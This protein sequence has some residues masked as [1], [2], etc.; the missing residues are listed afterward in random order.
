MALGLALGA[1]CARIVP[2][3]SSAKS[4]DSGRKDQTDE[5]AD[6]EAFPFPLE[7]PRQR[8]RMSE[9][10]VLLELFTGAQCPPCVAADIACDAVLRTYKPDEVVLLQYHLHIPR[11]D[12]LT[13]ADSEARAEYYGEAIEGTPTVFLDGKALSDELGGS[14]E[15]SKASYD[16]LR[17]RLDTA[18]AKDAGG[19]IKL[20]VRRTGDS[21][22]IE[23]EVADLTK[24]GDRVRLR[25]ALVE[26]VVRYAGRNGQRLHHHVV[27]AFPGGVNGF[28]LLDT[29]AKKKASVNLAALKKK[30]NDFLNQSAKERPFPDNERPLNLKRLKVI[31]FVQDDKSKEVYQAV[32][33]DVP[34]AK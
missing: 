24:A 5:E 13:N 26:G 11:P 7:A 29:P 14:R 16:A 32:E 19:R 22:D 17:K 31:A 3:S 12:P 10:V 30:L 8:R 28:A 18:L 33:A 23:S 1:S 15:D 21:I 6:K 34:E 2:S 27:R 20:D 25:F 4:E 9:R